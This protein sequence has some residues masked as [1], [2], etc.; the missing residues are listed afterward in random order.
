MGF[1]HSRIPKYFQRGVFSSLE[2]ITIDMIF[3]TS[4]GFPK[5]TEIIESGL[6]KG[7]YFVFFCIRFFLERS[8]LGF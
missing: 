8:K 3:Q 2:I 4:N 1:T 6:L 7:F 5:L